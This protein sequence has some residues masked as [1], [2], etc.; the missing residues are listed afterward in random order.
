MNYFKTLTIL[1]LISVITFYG[2]K[3]KT[4]APKEDSSTTLEVKDSTN[5]VN[6]ATPAPKEPAQNALGVWHYTCQMGCPG[7]AGKAEKCNTCGNILVHNTTYH[8]NTSNTS[9]APFASPAATP[10]ASK[11]PAQNAAGVWHYTCSNGCAGGSG[12]AGNCTTCNGA[13]VHNAA[14]H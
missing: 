1:L 10:P 14:Y 4:K 3:D 12:S 8:S 2:C 11:E 7:G 6:K 13:L 9:D 5:Q